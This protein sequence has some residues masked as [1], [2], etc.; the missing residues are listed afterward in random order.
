MAY[1]RCDTCPDHALIDVSD[2]DSGLS[3]SVRVPW[4]HRAHWIGWGDR[5]RANWSDHTGAEQIGVVLGEDETGADVEMEDGRRARLPRGT[6]KSWR[7]GSTANTAEMTKVA[8]KA[9]ERW[10][11]VRPN[12]PDTKGVPV[13]IRPM[14][15][16]SHK[17]VGGAGGKLNHLR[18][19]GVKEPHEYDRTKATEKKKETAQ[20][21]KARLDA[22]T[23]DARKAALDQEAAQRRHLQTKR[24]ALHESERDFIRQ[25]REKAGG[26]D[27]DLRAED[28]EKLPAGAADKR[29]KTHHRHQLRQ[30]LRRK[31]EVLQRF[32]EDAADTA[33]AKAARSAM[34][35]D[36]DTDPEV[37]D[38]VDEDLR[39]AEEERE[40]AKA[41]RVEGSVPVAS[42]ATASAAAAETARAVLSE[43][44][45]EAL[46]KQLEELSAK[47]ERSA[48]E[49]MERR[50][51]EA[52][53]DAALLHQAAELS[54]IHI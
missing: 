43:V 52:K 8:L 33:Q 38:M 9:G 3:F 10:I 49:E 25:V 32:A 54:L 36:D 34:H 46:T 4:E 26:V 1:R 35:E 16:G 19:H 6:Y 28:L 31:D 7:P 27:E 48:S 20:Q 23:P 22:M 13:L 39:L 45:H 41:D 14:P 17:I 11:T 40:E 12:G 42:P 21:R 51:M 18:L 30:A 50:A 29:R 2:A 44:D 24:D 53:R 47:P 37:V 15:D 5:P